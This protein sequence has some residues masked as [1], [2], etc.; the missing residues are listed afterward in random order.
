MHVRLLASGLIFLIIVL[1]L[2]LVFEVWMFVHLIRNQNIPPE[3]K[4]LWALG[5][6]I[7][8]PFV[9]IVYYFTDYRAQPGI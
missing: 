6:F 3:R 2:I 4:I 8:H 5:M 1:L 9:A 7:I